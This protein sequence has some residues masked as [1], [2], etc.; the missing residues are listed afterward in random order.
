MRRLVCAVLLGLAT[1]TPVAA[2]AALPSALT[3]GLYLYDDPSPDLPLLAR[4]YRDYATGQY[5]R[6]YFRLDGPG[7]AHVTVRFELDG[8]PLDAATEQVTLGSDGR[9]Y[10]SVEIVRPAP[11]RH[12]LTATADPGDGGEPA[13]VTAPHLFTPGGAAPTARGSGNLAGRAF[14]HQEYYNIAE[15]TYVRQEF[16]V[17]FVDRTWAHLGPVGGGR[18]RCGPAVADCE[19]YA[20]DVGT[21]LVQV[22]ADI[23]AKVDDS[24]AFFLNAG[25]AEDNSDY[26]ASPGFADFAPLV[27]VPAAARNG[28]R[29]TWTFSGNGEGGHLVSA[30][31]RFTQGRH[32]DMRY[33]VGVGTYD[34]T[35]RRLVG[36]YR[37]KGGDRLVIHYRGGAAHHRRSMTKV[38]SLLAQADPSGEPH[39]RTLGLYLA[40]DLGRSSDGALLT[41]ARAS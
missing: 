5:S 38:V 9:G 21:G 27:P 20:Y 22:G 25:F 6:L 34:V 40:L 23:L 11:G 8:D 37:I 17:W 7:R 26:D 30:R 39:V 32:I 12:S 2:T 1:L 10:A 19:R 3:I 33:F 36:W 24:T 28:L 18:P 15:A 31:L 35:R 14:S 16:L 41:P 29:G 13:T 4:D